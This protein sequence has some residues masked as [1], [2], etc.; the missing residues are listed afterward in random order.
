MSGSFKRCED[1]LSH[2]ARFG[3]SN[4]I[5]KNIQTPPVRH[6]KIYFFDPIRRGNIDQLI[7]Q[8]DDRFAALER[9]SFLTKILS[10]QKL[11]KLLSFNKLQQQLL[12][13]LGL[14]RVVINKTPAGSFHA[15]S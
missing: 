3:I 7:E 1:T 2:V 9:K 6:S 13:S 10:V 4:N 5:R 15:A 14:K 8:R 12:L 11:L